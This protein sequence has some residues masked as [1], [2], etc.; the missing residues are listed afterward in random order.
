MIVF[1]WIALGLIAGAL[2]GKR[3]RGYGYGPV[4]DRVLG[5]TGGLLGGFITEAT[6][7]G[8]P[9]HYVISGVGAILGAVAATGLI[10]LASGERRFSHN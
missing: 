4:M 3:M 1:T 5:I 10:G 6:G 7:W 9:Y 8:A 2:A